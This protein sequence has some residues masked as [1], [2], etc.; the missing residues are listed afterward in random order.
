MTQGCFFVSKLTIPISLKAS[1]MTFLISF[2][3][4]SIH[5]QVFSILSDYKIKYKDYFLARTIHGIIAS[6]LIYFILTIS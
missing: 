6:S 4:F 3:G 5:M 1:L 2:G